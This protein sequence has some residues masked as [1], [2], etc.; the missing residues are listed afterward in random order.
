MVDIQ[1]KKMKLFNMF[2]DEDMMPC[3]KRSN[4]LEGFHKYKIDL[5]KEELIVDNKSYP[6]RKFGNPQEALEV[7]EKEKNKIKKDLLSFSEL[8]KNNLENVMV[9]N[10]GN[11]ESF[12]IT[13]Q[14]IIEKRHYSKK[15]NNALLY[16]INLIRKEFKLKPI[17]SFGKLQTFFNIELSNE[18]KRYSKIKLETDEIGYLIPIRQL[19]LLDKK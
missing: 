14:T 5:D 4:M 12:Y 19:A 13:S 8:L 9:L 11:Y 15:F 6:L 2:L 17:E 16:H 7:I 10:L 3:F 18:L 1:I